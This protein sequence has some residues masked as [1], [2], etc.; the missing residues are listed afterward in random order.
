MTY[1]LAKYTLLFL[2]ASIISFILGYWWSRRKFVDVSDSFEAITQASSTNSSSWER[3]WQRL[4]AIGT[5]ESTDLSGVYGR[6]DGMTSSIDNLPI[7]DPENFAAI[8]VRID[9][10]NEYIRKTANRDVL[11]AADLKPVVENMA[12]IERTIASLPAPEKPA[13]TDLAP[14]TY[15]I[16]KLDESV[17]NIPKAAPARDVNLV[18]IQD[19]L[20]SL[21]TAIRSMSATP[22]V[23][24]AQ[25]DQLTRRLA[26]IENEVRGIP[27]SEPT[28]LKPVDRRLDSIE[29]E[30]RELGKRLSRPTPSQ[31]AVSKSVRKDPVL[32][33]SA[34]H[35]NKD[36]LKSVSG[37]GPKL[38]RLLNR[39]GIYYFWQISSWSKRDIKFID[40]RLDVFQGRIARDNWVRQAKKLKN[41]PSAAK[42]PG[43]SGQ[44]VARSGGGQI[45]EH[46]A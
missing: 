9:A 14:M 46:A 28:D 2:A 7:V 34:I 31:K 26:S 13:P 10:L 29:V 35:G 21:R 6:L 30:I 40:E 4:D 36:D 18:P 43:N 8:N 11:T 38:E 45:A 27:R 20:A 1:L 37:I 12:S 22:A 41:S 3:L 39:N 24:V 19:E 16:A 25:L 15:T 5:P 17:R 23:P 33:K 42:E 44:S 32:L